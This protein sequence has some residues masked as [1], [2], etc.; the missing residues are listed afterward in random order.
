M[1]TSHLCFLP[2]IFLCPSQAAF[3]WKNDKIC[4]DA[5]TLVTSH[6]SI[7]GGGRGT[8]AE[9]VGLF[10]HK[11]CSHFSHH[12]SPHL[13]WLNGYKAYYF[14]SLPAFYFVSGEKNGKEARQDGHLFF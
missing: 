1:R 12:S 10:C 5:Y 7:W 13:G 2:S 14:P 9:K 8:A 4:N 3:L 6:D 11:K